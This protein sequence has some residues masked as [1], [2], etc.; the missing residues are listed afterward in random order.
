MAVEP[1]RVEQCVKFVGCDP[2]SR[3]QVATRETKVPSMRMTL[4]SLVGAALAL[5]LGTAAF[6]QGGPASVQVERVDRVRVEETQQLVARL[7]AVN[8]STVATRIPGIV[9][10]VSVDVGTVVSKGDTLAALDRELL[11]IELDGAEAGLLEAEA[12]L[13]VAEANVDLAQQVYERTTGL[14]GSAAYSEGRAQDLAKELARAKG[15]LARA[16]AALAIARSQLGQARYR[17]NNATIT[18]PYDGVVVRRVASVGDYVQAGGPIARVID[19][20]NLE[21]EADVPTEIVAALN[22]GDTVSAIIDDGTLGRATVRAVVPSEN[23]STRTRPVRFDIVA[24]DSRKSLAAGQSVTIL[25]PVGDPRDALAVSKDALV[26]QAGRWI[27]F[28]AEDGKARPQPVTIGAAIAG[29]FEVEG[30]LSEG[31][32]VVVRGNERLRPGQAIKFEPPEQAGEESAALAAADD[33][34]A[35]N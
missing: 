9:A 5:G 28:V 31:D 35:T 33:G 24:D 29:R 12:G 25:A 2:T 14:Q 22:P 18:A 17:L 23:P 15:E 8:E 3:L 4:L 20:E 6:A 19:N 34:K 16:E 27:V 30:G 10:S 21:V 1:S 7:V 26:Q 11:R 13:R 32:L